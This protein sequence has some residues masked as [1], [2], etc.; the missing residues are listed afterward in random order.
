MIVGSLKKMTSGS[1]LGLAMMTNRTHG[2]TLYGNIRK[3]FEI[4]MQNVIGQL[5]YTLQVII[6]R[7][8]ISRYVGWGPNVQFQ[9][10][11]ISTMCIY[12]NCTL[13]IENLQRRLVNVQM[14]SQEVC[15]ALKHLLM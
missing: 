2:F 12:M 6:M 8:L 5:P 15:K 1:R 4:Y 10:F 14:S 9:H 11:I 3:H 13:A 7:N